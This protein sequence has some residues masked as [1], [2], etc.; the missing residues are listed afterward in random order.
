MLLYIEFN[1]LSCS[2]ILPKLQ[3]SNSIVKEQLKI[4]SLVA[5]S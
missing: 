5:D 4:L 2:D 3:I 1:P